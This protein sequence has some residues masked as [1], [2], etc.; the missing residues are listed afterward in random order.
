MREEEQ[1]AILFQ[2]CFRYGF[3]R[4]LFVSVVM[5]RFLY[6]GGHP[7]VFSLFWPRFGFGFTVIFV[8]AYTNCGYLQIECQH[9]NWCIS[10]SRVY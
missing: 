10:I 3:D 8:D 6:A 7:F 2:C 1:N 4:F 9:V 5:N